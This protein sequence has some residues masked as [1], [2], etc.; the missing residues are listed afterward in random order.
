MTF[1]ERR[2]FVREFLAGEGYRPEVDKDGDIFIKKEGRTLYVILD[3]DDTGYYR[4]LLPTID[5]MEENESKVPYYLACNEGNRVVKVAKVW[6]Q[7][8][9]VHVTA[10]TFFSDVEAFTKNLERILACCLTIQYK[11]SEALAK[12]RAQINQTEEDL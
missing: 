11:Y 6:I 10:E 7:E 5:R 8:D 12:A 3:D 1:Y 2:D 4:V 9:T